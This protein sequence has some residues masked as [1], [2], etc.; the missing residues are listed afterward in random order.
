VQ[1][2]HV[3]SK[4]IHKKHLSGNPTYCIDGLF[5]KEYPD[6]MA[7][8]PHHLRHLRTKRNISQEKLAEEIGVSRPTYLQIEKG[9]RELTVTE[10]QKLARIFGMSLEDF[11]EE[12]ELRISLPELPSRQ[13]A[14][15]GKTD[16][17][18]NVPQERMAKFREVLLY[19]LK[20]VGAKPNVGETVLYKILYFIDFDFYEKFEEQFMGLRYIKNHHG[21][22]PI[23]FTQ[24]VTKMEREK[25][26]VR[27]KGKYFQYDQKKYMPLREPDLSKIDS[28]ELQHIDVELARLSDMNAAQIRD[29]SHEDIPWKVHKMGESLDYEYVFYREAPYS[30]R[31]Y[32]NDPL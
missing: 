29:F 13:K 2:V 8:D 31:S 15:R 5:D 27:V 16:M 23:G 6:A 11:L 3:L 1:A 18:I 12:K 7:F 30:V 9:E 14:V 22:S 21:P 24:M 28:R 25:D 26:L 19:I 4:I 32:D 17:R 20:R 10:A